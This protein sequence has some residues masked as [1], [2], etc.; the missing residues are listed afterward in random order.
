[1]KDSVQLNII[2]EGVST[3]AD[4][5][6]GMRLSTSEMT[7]EE[8]LWILD[9]QNIPCLATFQ[10]IEGFSITKE[11]KSELSKKTISE[12]IRACVFI[13]WK[14]SGE[15]GSFEIFYASEGEKIISGLKAKLKPV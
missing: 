10:P 2:V 15:P 6:L 8:K 7:P 5:S 11:I 13:F 4:K 9:L 1:M 12:R 3:R 14:Q